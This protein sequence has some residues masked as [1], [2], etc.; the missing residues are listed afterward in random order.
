MKSSPIYN[1]VH[2]PGRVSDCSF[3]VKDYFSQD[4][5]VGTSAKN[6]HS[7]ADISVTRF[8]TDS[9]AVQFNLF[10]D[11]ELFKRGHLIGKDFNFDTSLEKHV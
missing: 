10:I 2:N 8:V 11:G 5:R 9:G 6:S 3:G 7:L 4:I 1:I